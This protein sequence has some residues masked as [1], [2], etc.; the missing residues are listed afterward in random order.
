MTYT[1]FRY[2]TFSTSA[3]WVGVLSSEKGLLCNTFPQPSEE[4]AHRHL[5]DS[6]SL[7]EGSPQQ[8]TDFAE[9]LRTYFSGGKVAFQDELDFTGATPFQCRVWQA[10]RLIPHGQTLSYGQVAE[11]IGSP[12]ASRAVGHA[13]GK[14]RLPII[15]PCHRVLASDGGLCGFGG[16]LPMKKY[17]LSLESKA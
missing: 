17:L 11:R 13:L 8:F 10:T 6:A 15:V 9:R 14:N 4:E 16:G 2:F 1:G 12:G 7:A 5:G 3:G